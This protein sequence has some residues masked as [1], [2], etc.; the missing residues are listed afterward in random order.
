[1]ITQKKQIKD[2][3]KKLTEYLKQLVDGK[4]KKTELLRKLLLSKKALVKSDDFYQNTDEFE[5]KISKVI[6]ISVPSDWDNDN[7][8]YRLTL[9]V[10]LK[11]E[12]IEAPHD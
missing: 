7:N 9:S 5:S 11:I 12:R 3:V 8:T 4:I 6:E 2:S 1:M 10:N